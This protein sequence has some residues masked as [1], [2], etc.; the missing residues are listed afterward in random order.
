MSAML[1]VE[2]VNNDWNLKWSLGGGEVLNNWE[3]D[4]EKMGAAL[5]RLETCSCSFIKI[6]N[7]N[8]MPI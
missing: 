1:K 4:L 8:K 2:N 5:K 3:S 6:E 7:I